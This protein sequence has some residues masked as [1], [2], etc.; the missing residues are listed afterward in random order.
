MK[1][2]LSFTE[3]GFYTVDF[4]LAVT[5][6]DFELTLLPPPPQMLD[7]PRLPRILEKHSANRGA[8]LEPSSSSPETFPSLS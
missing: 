7:K 3:T 8:S 2:E 5:E 1:D 4:R 6:A